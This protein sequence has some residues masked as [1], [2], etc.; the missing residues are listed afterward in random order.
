MYDPVLLTHTLKSG[1]LGLFRPFIDCSTHQLCA[2]AVLICLCVSLIFHV[3]TIIQACRVNQP[4][5]CLLQ[6]PEGLH[7]HCAL[8]QRKHSCYFYDEIAVHT[9]NINVFALWTNSNINNNNSRCKGDRLDQSLYQ[10]SGPI[11][12][13]HLWYGYNAVWLLK[14]VLRHLNLH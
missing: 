12:V 8:K 6:G 11:S 1:H 7:Q 9:L 5:L 13:A 3:N 4:G 10:K 2:N 14:K